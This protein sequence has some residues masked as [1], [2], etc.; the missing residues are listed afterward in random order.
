MTRD[1][2]LQTL[3][4]VEFKGYSFHL[5]PWSSERIY[6]Q[7]EFVAPCAKTGFP[8]TQYTRK[9]YVSNEATHSEVVQTCLKCVLTSMEH[10]A[11]E[12]FLY[13]GRAIFGPHFNVDTLWEVCGQE[14]VR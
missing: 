4:E 2:I 13:K 8:E 3:R 5:S 6:L 9:W 7:A 1:E 14:D 10:E 11:R 12:R